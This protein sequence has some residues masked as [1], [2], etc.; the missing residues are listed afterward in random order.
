MVSRNASKGILLAFLIVIIVMDHGRQFA[1]KIGVVV[2]TE[3][4]QVAPAVVDGQKMGIPENNHQRASSGDG[5]VHPLVAAHE[6]QAEAVISP[7]NGLRR[8]YS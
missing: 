8:A 1:S 4:D 7:E 5:H 3:E 6:S 2:G